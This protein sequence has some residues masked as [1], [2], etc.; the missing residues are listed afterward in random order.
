MNRGHCFFYAIL[1][2]LFQLLEKLRYILV[3]RNIFDCVHED[4]TQLEETGQGI[5]F[6]QKVYA[7]YKHE[8]ACYWRFSR[9]KMCVHNEP[10]HII[11]T[12]MFNYGYE[13]FFSNF[14]TVVYS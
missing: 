11:K 5:C 14:R 7:H 3:V 6:P 12:V 4:Y 9:P 8:L 13:I 1:Y 2:Y 10:V